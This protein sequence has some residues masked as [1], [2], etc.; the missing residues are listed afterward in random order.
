MTSKIKFIH[1]TQEIGEISVDSL[2]VD[3]DEPSLFLFKM[4][5]GDPASWIEF[6]TSGLI[7]RREYPY[8]PGTVESEVKERLTHHQDTLYLTSLKNSDS[9]TV[10]VDR[11]MAEIIPGRV[12]WTETEG[13]VVSYIDKDNDI[14]E[15]LP[16]FINIYEYVPFDQYFN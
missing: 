15:H 5:H 2:D 16:S 7:F 3:L 14:E 1:L 12:M 13:E 8:E 11:S 10:G 4:T 6:T 9:I